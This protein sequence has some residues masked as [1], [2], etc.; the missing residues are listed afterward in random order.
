MRGYCVVRGCAMLTY[1]LAL[2]SRLRLV[3]ETEMHPGP[4]WEGQGCDCLLSE[5]EE[6][7]CFRVDGV[8]WVAL[9]RAL[10]C[11]F[12]FGFYFRWEWP[13]IMGI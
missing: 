13:I 9:V 5:S 3:L 1:P 7:C 2:S 10:Y 8:F 12:T 6:S 11:G 4:A